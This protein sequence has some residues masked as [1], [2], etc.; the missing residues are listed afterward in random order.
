MRCPACGAHYDTPSLRCPEC[1]ALQ[2]KIQV[3]TAVQVQLDPVATLQET[4]P[5]KVPQKNRTSRANPS[6][7]E[8]PGITRSAIPEWR[9]ELGE[10]VREVQER[11]AREATVS[12]GEIGSLFTEVEPRPGA[13]LELLPQAEMPPV[14]PLVVAA[15]RR[16]ERAHLQPSGNGALATAVVYEEQPETAVV[17][18]ELENPMDMPSKPERVHNL[19]VVPTPEVPPAEIQPEI[20]KPARVIDDQNPALNYLDSIPTSVT[21]D[22]REFRSAP[23][24][25]RS[26]SGITDLVVICLL[27]A[28][29]LAL[30]ELTTLQWRSPRMIGFGAGI[31]L[32]VSFLYL[33]VSIAF[34]GRTIGKKLFSLRV[35]D[36]RTG[37]IPTGSQSAGRALV[38][39]LSLASAGVALMYTFIDRERHTIHDRFTRTAVIRA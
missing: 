11:K 38:Y 18:S 4:K 6:L 8:F 36:A 25:R 37:L 24:I 33:T 21:V 19:A 30:T 15:L 27:S 1:G 22:R 10:R 20:R 5:A 29:F 9:R 13:S 23:I 3:Q 17:L 35:V 14:N 28:P 34:T 2:E 7:I 39:V 26:L 16:I 31:F 32:V 12:S